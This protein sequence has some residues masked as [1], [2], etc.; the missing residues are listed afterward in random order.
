MTNQSKKTGRPQKHSVKEL[1][2]IID[3]YIKKNAHKVTKLSATKLAQYATKE[4]G[5]PTHYQDFTRKKEVKEYI[6]KFNKKLLKEL[7]SSSL[8]SNN[9]P[10]YQKLNIKK[11][12]EKNNTRVKLEKALTLLDKHRENV[13]DSY[14]QIFDEYIKQ[15]EESHKK[16]AKIKD[17]Q[18]KINELEKVNDSKMKEMRDKIKETNKKSNLYRKKYVILE[19]FIKR[20]HY[21]TIVEY[22]LYIEGIITSGIEIKNQDI[23]RLDDYKSGKYDLTEVIEAYNFING[24][25][26]DSE[27]LD[28]DE[29][30]V[31]LEE[32]F[33]QD[34]IKLEDNDEITQTIHNEEYRNEVLKSKN[35]FEQDR[36][37]SEKELEDEIF[38]DL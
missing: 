32:F 26:D 3:L 12:I 17:L 16:D 34:S 5:K 13:H 37:K 28:I 38:K 18:N 10:I 19:N 23:F 20:Y 29:V 14:A 21:E 24:I 33:E 2:E 4:L 7:S 31:S 6:D 9:I 35:E 25:P 1:K 30:A 11:F 8:A 22:S 27:S 36:I 15:V